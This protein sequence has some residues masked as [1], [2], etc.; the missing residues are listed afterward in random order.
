M[1]VKVS[2]C[3][4]GE[5]GTDASPALSRAYVLG[6][7][8]LTCSSMDS[9]G[10]R[11]SLASD[12]YCCARVRASVKARVRACLRR[13]ASSSM[14]RPTLLMRVL[15]PPALT[16]AVSAFEAAPTSRTLMVSVLVAV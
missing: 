7:A 5:M 14:D 1:T 4:P 16:A 15:L 13:S 6:D 8:L 9:T 3:S 10:P 11:S 2:V 12:A